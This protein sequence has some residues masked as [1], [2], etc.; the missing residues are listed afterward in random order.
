VDGEIRPAATRQGTRCSTL[1]DR[2]QLTE[3]VA[4]Q[5][6]ELRHIAVQRWNLQVAIR[7][8]DGDEAHRL[9]GRTLHEKLD[10]TM[11]VGGAECS[12]GR[13]SDAAIAGRAMLSQALRPKLNEPIGNVAQLVG[14]GHQDLHVPSQLRVR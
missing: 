11:L 3:P 10:L 9:I 12:E 1:L 7:L 5:I 14:V 8:A 6:P 13:W 4:T 2:Q